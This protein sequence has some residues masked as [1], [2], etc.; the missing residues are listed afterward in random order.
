MYGEPISFIDWLIDMPDE[1]SFWVEDQMAAL[2]PGPI[3]VACAVLLAILAGIWLLIISAAKKDVR[4]TSEILA[5][6]EEVNRGYEFYDVDEEI[7]LEYS[8]ESLEEFR[9]TS[10][11]KLFMS[12]VREKVPQFEEVF[13]W[14][15]SNA[16]Q[17]A[18]YKEEL[19]TIPDWTEKDD[20]CGRRT[21]FRL[22]KHYEQK[23]VNAAVLGTPVTEATFIAVKQYVPHKGK[24]MEESKTYSMAEAKEFVR[25]AKAHEREHQQREN[26]RRQASSQIKYEVLQRDGFRCVVC[27][28]TPE[29][30]AKLH[31]QAVK[32]LPKHERP[33]ADCFRT[34]CEDCMRKKG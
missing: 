23:L 6:V 17:F 12:T 14:A 33:S 32:P 2:T 30:G 7:R 24:P 20:D 34:V 8:L 11:D 10:L 4:N 25:L 18:A 3:A 19:K 27:G 29:Q 5:G 28:M 21:F 31:I 1:F 22:Y 26:E 16:I 15:Q 9:G 13:S